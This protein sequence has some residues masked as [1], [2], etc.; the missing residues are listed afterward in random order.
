MV[1]GSSGV[2]YESSGLRIEEVKMKSQ[3]VWFTTRDGE[4]GLEEALRPAP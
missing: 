4:H 3:S 1:I 2:L